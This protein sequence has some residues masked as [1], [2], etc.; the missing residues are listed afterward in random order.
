[1][2]F[3]MLKNLGLFIL[4]EKYINFYINVNYLFLFLIVYLCKLLPNNV[5]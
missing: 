5:D 3:F 4:V 1:M 2:K